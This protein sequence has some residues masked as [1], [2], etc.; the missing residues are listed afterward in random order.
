MNLEH[1]YFR[2]AF[3][4]KV[5]F[6]RCHQCSALFFFCSLWHGTLP[7]R[8]SGHHVTHAEHGQTGQHEVGLLFRWDPREPFASCVALK[9]R[10]SSENVPF[11]FD[12]C[13][14]PALCHFSDSILEYLANLD[15]AP[16]PTVRKDTFSS[17]IGAAFDILFNN[18]LQ[19]RES[20]VRAGYLCV[21]ESAVSHY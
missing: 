7:Q 16:D 19:S 2:V 6:F 1:F 15:K 9:K 21:T 3:E 4:R 11:D 10:N 17:E 14:S 13:A 5:E 12:V 20:K 18:W 8:Y